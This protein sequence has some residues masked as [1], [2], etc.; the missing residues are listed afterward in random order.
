MGTTGSV[1]LSVSPTATDRARGCCLKRTGTIHTFSCLY[2]TPCC[3]FH[4]TAD[5][6]LPY[7]PLVARRA[8]GFIGGPHTAMNGICRRVVDSLGD[9]VSLLRKCGH[10][11]SGAHV[12]RRITCKLHTHTRL[13]V[14]V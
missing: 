8:A 9:T 1:V 3:R 5:G 7:I 2:L 12:S 6:S 13:C 14:K 4:C 11:K 10:R